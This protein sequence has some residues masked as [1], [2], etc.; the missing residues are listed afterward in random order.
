MRKVLR[1]VVI[2]LLVVLPLWGIIIFTTLMT[3]MPEDLEAQYCANVEFLVQEA[4]KCVVKPEMWR[5]WSKQKEMFGLLEGEGLADATNCPTYIDQAIRIGLS[6]EQLSL[7]GELLN[8]KYSVPELWSDV[9][10]HDFCSFAEG[11]GWTARLQ[12]IRSGG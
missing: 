8:D 5:A 7:I 2:G 12:A 4:S 1:K 6:T 10:N 9:L 3:L 11:E